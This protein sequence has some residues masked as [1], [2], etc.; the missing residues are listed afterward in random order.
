MIMENYANIPIFPFRKIPESGTLLVPTNATACTDTAS[1]V[2]SLE[3]VQLVMSLKHRHRGHLSIELISPSGTRSQI[4]KTR[5]NDHS[6]KGL[7]VRHV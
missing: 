2:R 5:R 6:N 1:E 4:L 3:H 7:K